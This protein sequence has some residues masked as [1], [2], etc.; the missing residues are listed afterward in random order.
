MTYDRLA[1]LAERYL[2]R[3]SVGKDMAIRSAALASAIDTSDTVRQ[4][5][6]RFQV[7]HTFDQREPARPLSLFA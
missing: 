6:V 5:L 3:L 4:A 1:S 2:H 7:E